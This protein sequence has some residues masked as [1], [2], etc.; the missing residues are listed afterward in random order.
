MNLSFFF[1]STISNVFAS[2]TCNYHRKP[3]ELRTACLKTKCLNFITANI[4]LFTHL[5]RIEIQHAKNHNTQQAIIENAINLIKVNTLDTLVLDF[6]SFNDTSFGMKLIELL[7][8]STTINLELL[9]FKSIYLPSF[10][11]LTENIRI[12]HLLLVSCTYLT[13]PERNQVMKAFPNL[14]YVEYMPCSEYEFY[15]STDT[16]LSIVNRFP[17]RNA[18]RYEYVKK[19]YNSIFF[20]DLMLSY[21]IETLE[22]YNVGDIHGIR[23][24]NVLVTQFNGD[25][26]RLCLRFGDVRSMHV[27]ND[28]LYKLLKRRSRL[29]ALDI[30]YTLQEEHMN[31]SFLGSATKLKRFSF[32]G[33]FNAN[34]CSR[35]FHL[36]RT[37]TVLESVDFNFYRKDTQLLEF[38]TFMEDLTTAIFISKSIKS[39][40]VKLFIIY[41]DIHPTMDSF[42]NI[43]RQFRESFLVPIGNAREIL[44]NGIPIEKYTTQLSNFK[45]LSS[46]KLKKDVKHFEIDYSHQFFGGLAGHLE[47]TYGV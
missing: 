23:T 37:S 2:D 47:K 16:Y 3:F 39:I 8:H 20:G 43:M 46:F 31:L 38:L 28:L 19:S 21:A 14:V 1:L 32:G 17:R 44:F 11:N 6:H 29:D 9:H 12:R 40:N 41:P 30:S 27:W 13:I 10:A 45:D 22:L 33:P 7:S 25:L 15:D 5:K 26:K 36:I 42:L 35:I 24:E 34:E 18:E 4:N